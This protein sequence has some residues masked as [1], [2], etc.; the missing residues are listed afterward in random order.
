VIA[1]DLRGLGKIVL[2]DEAPMLTS[3]SAWTLAEAEV[4]G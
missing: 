3:N 1:L 2:T 4:A